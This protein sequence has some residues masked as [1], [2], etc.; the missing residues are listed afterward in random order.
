MPALGAERFLLELPRR[1]E[2]YDLFL[3]PEPRRLWDWLVDTPVGEMDWLEEPTP[4]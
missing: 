1:L 3:T 4:Q 2:Y